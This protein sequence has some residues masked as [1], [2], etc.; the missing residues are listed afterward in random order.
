MNI[1]I[2][3]IKPIDGDIIAESAAKTGK[4]LTVEEH[5]I[6]GGLG[7]AV[8]DV[9]AERCPTKVV[10]I[11]V[12]DEFGHSGPAKDLLKQFGLSAENIVNTVT[13]FVK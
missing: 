1:N 3:T 13:D 10:K 7:S 8:C 9:L 5:S 2:H 11:G 6:I 4:V 12:N